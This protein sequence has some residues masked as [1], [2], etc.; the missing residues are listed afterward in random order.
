MLRDVA[1]VK[2]W[3]LAEVKYAVEIL[4][5]SGFH[6]LPSSC[7]E[8]QPDMLTKSVSDKMIR[9]RFEK[10][11]QFLHVADSNNLPKDTK[12]G[13]VSEYLDEE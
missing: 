9:N 2:Y 5:L 1:T 11:L 4:I 13:R 3:L 10:I 8:Q 12:V 6:R 7:W